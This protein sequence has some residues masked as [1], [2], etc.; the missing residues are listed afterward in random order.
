MNWDMILNGECSEEGNKEF[1]IPEKY[2]AKHF[3]QNNA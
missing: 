3:G 2:I 1:E